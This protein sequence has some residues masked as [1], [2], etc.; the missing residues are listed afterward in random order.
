MK[1]SVH[2]VASVILA[3]VLYHFFKWKVLLILVG[4][5]LID[6]DHYFWYVYK[7]RKFNFFDSYQFYIKNIEINDFT[8]VAGILLVFHTLEFLL[9]VVLLS[10]YYEPVFIFTIGLISHY[11][12]DFIFLSFIAKRFIANHS[13]IH[14]VYKN[15]LKIQKL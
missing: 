10:F 5:V 7:Y 11:L 9:I 6:V 14:W 2:V 12:L 13:I 15:K 8:N 4:G 3:A 1:T